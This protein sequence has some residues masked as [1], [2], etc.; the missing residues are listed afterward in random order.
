M[1]G[2]G[3]LG[4]ICAMD[5]K[6]EFEAKNPPAQAWYSRPVV[7]TPEGGNAGMTPKQAN[8]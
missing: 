8:G 6:A 1:I 2:L 7:W 3:L 5:Q 4:A